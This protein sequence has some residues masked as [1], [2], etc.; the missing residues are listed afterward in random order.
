MQVLAQ[1]PG[2]F[3]IVVPINVIYLLI[4]QLMH[5]VIALDVMQD[6]HEAW[7]AAQIFPPESKKLFGPQPLTNLYNY[8]YLS[9]NYS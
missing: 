8:Y 1:V 2:L 7:H 3:A 6:K 5:Y 4:G 9:Y